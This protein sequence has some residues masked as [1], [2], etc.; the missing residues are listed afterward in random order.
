MGYFKT[1]LKTLRGSLHGNLAHD[2][3][4]FKRRLKSWYWY[5]YWLQDFGVGNGNIICLSSSIIWLYE[6]TLAVLIAGN[7]SNLVLEEQVSEVK[8]VDS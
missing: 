3:L 7:I 4:F 8:T 2:K 6:V 1:Y 5:R